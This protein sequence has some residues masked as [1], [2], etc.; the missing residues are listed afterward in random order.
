[1]YERGTYKREIHEI[2]I[3]ESG[4]G[5]RLRRPPAPGR[6]RSRAA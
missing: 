5:V 4:A 2:G 6:P 1:M 3:Y